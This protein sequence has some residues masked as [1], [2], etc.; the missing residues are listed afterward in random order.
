MHIRFHIT[1]SWPFWDVSTVTLLHHI[2][3]NKIA[4]AYDLQPDMQCQARANG[5]SQWIEL[6][7]TMPASIIKKKGPVSFLQEATAPKGAIAWP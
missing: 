2:R 7:D 5:K 1:V 3:C 6:P 4:R